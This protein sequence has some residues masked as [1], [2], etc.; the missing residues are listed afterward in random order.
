MLIERIDALRL[1][2]AEQRSIRPP[3]K[4]RGS[5]SLPMIRRKR[6]GG[7]I[8]KTLPPPAASVEFSPSF[9]MSPYCAG[10]RAL[11]M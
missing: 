7:A 5:S 2:A 9:I 1:E 3:A 11:P 4:S 6:P 8:V 10:R